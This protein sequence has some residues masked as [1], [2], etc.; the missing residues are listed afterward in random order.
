MVAAPCTI[1]TIRGGQGV[2]G[3]VEDQEPSLIQTHGH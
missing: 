2:I 1:V 3:L